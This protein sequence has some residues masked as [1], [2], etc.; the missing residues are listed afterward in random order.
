MRS[1]IHRSQP[2][3]TVPCRLLPSSVLRSTSSTRST[4]ATLPSISTRAST[5]RSSWG[6]RRPTEDGEPRSDTSTSF[7]SIR[8]VPSTWRYSA[9]L[10]SSR[11]VTR[12]AAHVCDGQHIDT[13]R[14]R[15]FVIMGRTMAGHRINGGVP[16]RGIVK[17]DDALVCF[18]WCMTVFLVLNLFYKV[19]A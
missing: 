12:I 13:V 1:R 8:D 19:Y 5:I 4:A 16:L 18:C 10:I 15:I 9:R 2:D 17:L 11:W 6:T 14:K 7:H 3:L